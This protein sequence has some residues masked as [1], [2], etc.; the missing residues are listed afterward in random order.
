MNF[1]RNFTTEEN[2]ICVFKLRIHINQ[3]L[4]YNLAETFRFELQ[5]CKGPLIN[6]LLFLQLLLTEKNLSHRYEV[7]DNASHLCVCPEFNKELVYENNLV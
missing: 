1:I 7:K 2:Y 6:K 3:F 4:N 5:T